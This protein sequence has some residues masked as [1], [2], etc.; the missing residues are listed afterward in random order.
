MVP[1]CGRMTGTVMTAIILPPT[2]GSMN[3]MSVVF[4]SQTSSVASLV[5]PV[6][7]RQAKR[8]AKSRPLIVPP[9]KTAVG[10]YFLHSTVKRLA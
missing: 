6:G 9:T 2:A 8:G 10:R 1:T 3:S 4:G 7:R 5:Q